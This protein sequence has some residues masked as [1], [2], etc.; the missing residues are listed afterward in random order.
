MDKI[1]SKFDKIL[2]A[3]IYVGN[4]EHDPDASKE[5]LSN[6]KDKTMPFPD[7]T[8]NYQRNKGIPSKS[9][10]DS[11]VYIVGSGIAGLSAAYYFIRDGH[12]PGK[13]I[14][15]LDQLSIEGG[16]LDGAGNAE[17]G[18]II[19][20]GREMEMTYEN[21]W[22]I[23]QDIPALEMPA[24]Y[25]VLDEYRLLNDND[26][27]Y[28]KARL[29]HNKGDIQ[30]FSKFGLDKRDQLAIVKLLL[31]K[32][33]DLNDLTIEDYFSESFLQSNFWFLW[34]TMFAFENWHSL[35]ECKLY[36]HRFLH[37]IDGM[38]D[39]SCLVFP[40]YNQYD[41]FVKPLTEHL[42]SKGVK[43]Q[44]DTLVKDLDI[45]INSEE[46]I[47]K[48]IITEQNNKEVVIPVGENDYVI[49]TTGS[50]TEDTSYGTN[51]KPAIEAIDNS[52]SGTSDGW[53]LWKNLAAKSSVFGKPEKFCSDIEKSAWQSATLTCRPSD[54]TEK[55]KEYCVN[56][57]YSGRTATGGIV[58][59]TDSNWL[60]SFTINRQP[61]YPTQ[62]DDILVV[63]VYALYIDKQGNH[64][65]KTL[66]QCTGNEIL[67]E[68]C[69][70]LGLENQLE[71]AIE[72]TIVRT[73]FMPY[74][75]SMFLPRAVGDRPEIVPNGCKNLGLVG[76]FVETKNDVVFTVESSVRTARTAVYKLLNSNKQVPDIAGAQYDIRH[77]LKAT[78][79]LNDYKSFPGEGILKRVLKN[80]YFEHVLPMD[81]EPEE[82]HNSFIEEQFGKLQEWAKNL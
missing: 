30:D 79:A 81:E 58:T 67:S 66:P 35:L 4:V 41:T 65:Q 47:V 53:K 21:L 44:F 48:G 32:K 28:S 57:P 52:Q 31:K 42:K 43:I 24:P 39:L 2:S 59:I 62:P 38:K 6:S 64:V 22:D 49:V 60:M 46:K 68:L 15:F 71:N 20:G 51:T 69:Y 5:V 18:Y 33:E 45:H 27:N 75:T 8:G 55:F 63:W 19:R 40:K 25:S 34:R 29:I 37:T 73:A 72:N 70:H 77:L 13:N 7:L 23:F 80:T 12:I 56:D 3:S 61:H 1:T 9:F 14:V 74:I 11:K 50:M 78:K 10:K 54:L 26:P 76:Q 16:S 17:D 36:M 82:H